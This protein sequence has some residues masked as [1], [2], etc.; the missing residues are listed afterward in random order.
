MCSGNLFKKIVVFCLPLMLM[1]IMQLL[2]NAADLI[3]VSNFSSDKEALG[4]VGSTTTLINLC[5]NLFMGLSVGT[6]VLVAKIYG[7]KK[8]DSLSDVVHTSL[9]T[10]LIIGLVLGFAGI[11]LADKLLNLMSNDL[12]LSRVYLQ[13]YFFGMPFNLI[14]NFASA[15]LRAVGDT[16]R[17]LY[18]LLISGAVNVGLNLFF[19]I[20][21][22]MS[23]AGVAIAT[24]IS[25]ILCC[26][27]I[28]NAL[29][30]EKEPYRF[31]FKEL[32]INPKIL[33]EIFKIGIPAGISSTIFSLSNTIIQSSVN[34]FGY[35]A[36]NGNSAAISIEGFVY[37]SM[38]SVYHAA[39]A[40]ASQNYGAKNTKNIKKVTI[41]S[42]IFVTMV[43]LTFGLTLFLLGRTVIRIYTQDP[44]SIE[45]AY[46]R[47]HY[48]CLPYFLCGIMDVMVGILR[49]IGYSI[50]PM[51]VSI[52]GVCGFRI[53]W[54]YAVFYN[55]T[56][57]VK[58]T[59]LNYLYMSYP[60]SWTITFLIQLISYFITSRKVYPR[61]EKEKEMELQN[62]ISIIN[63]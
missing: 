12:T 6:N 27:L 53:A 50:L 63:E 23:V 24:V 9:L 13:I 8:Y 10:S 28:L 11:M 5:V 38:N 18:Y 42:L 1:G 7:S 2:Y 36:M 31:R 57:F 19:C 48:L 62:Q 44:E 15:I 51:L 34:K 52:I 14:Y 56:D 60:I 22:D 39:L 21:L 30:R 49:G 16:K 41:Y 3:I 55:I 20:V 46:I 35:I 37:T 32:K 54:I 47:L 40:F 43:A 17:P 61:L 29:H 58:L 25:Q 45:V 33:F 26:V 59:D 4:A